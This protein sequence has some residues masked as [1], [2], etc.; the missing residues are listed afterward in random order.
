MATSKKKHIDVEALAKIAPD[1]RQ[2]EDWAA[3]AARTVS[4]QHTGELLLRF[5]AVHAP[6]VA[7]VSLRLAILETIIARGRIDSN[8]SRNYACYH[9]KTAENVRQLYEN[10]KAS[11]TNHDPHFLQLINV[12][13]VHCLYTARSPTCRSVWPFSRQS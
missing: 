13:M 7:D 10:A 11:R 6:A 4:D 9:I 3:H 1:L 2:I 12:Y 5:Y 8:F